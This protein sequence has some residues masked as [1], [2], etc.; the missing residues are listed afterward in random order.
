MENLKKCFSNKFLERVLELGYVLP[1]NDEKFYLVFT[2]TNNNKAAFID[3]VNKSI[4]I[5]ELTVLD[6]NNLTLE[7]KEV[8][9][10]GCNESTAIWILNKLKES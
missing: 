9:N 3:K 7:H 6:H 10:E 2:N 4:A 1:I 5:T 8:V